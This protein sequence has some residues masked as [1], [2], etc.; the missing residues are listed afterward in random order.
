MIELN[1]LP[2]VKKEFIKAQRMRNAVVSGAIVIS[3]VAG[4]VVVLLAT[5]VYGAQ[6]LMINGMKNE[7]AKNHKTLTDKQEINKYVAIQSQLSTVNGLAEERS[8]FARLFEYLPQLNPAPPSNV[9][10][11]SLVL[12]KEGSRIEII[13]SANDFESI[14]N[15]RTTLQQAK[16]TYVQDG[17]DSEVAFFTA[18][19]ADNPSLSTESG[20][21]RANF[22]MTLTYSPEIF[23]YAISDSKVNVPKLVTSDGDRVAPKEL[24]STSGQEGSDNE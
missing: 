3:L 15:F 10:L 23:S 9:T 1:L 13:G 22:K 12:N 4:G 21:V 20:K 18:I 2:D 11:S 24:F 16:L 7:I 5:T 14:N 6:A 19:E 17:K 8:V